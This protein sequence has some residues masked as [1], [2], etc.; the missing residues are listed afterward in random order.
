MA[1][2]KNRP[3]E[4][5]LIRNTTNVFMTEEILILEDPTFMLMYY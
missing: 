2:Q 4:T 3:G 5:H 1:T